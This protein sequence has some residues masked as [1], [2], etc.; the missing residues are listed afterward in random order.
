MNEMNLIYTTIPVAN[1]AWDEGLML[2]IPV[3]K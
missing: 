1:E 3:E 2:G